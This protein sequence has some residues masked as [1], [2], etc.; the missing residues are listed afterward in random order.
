MGFC[1]GS[2]IDCYSTGY[3]SGQTRV[4]GLV[5]SGVKDKDG[6]LDCAW[7]IETSGLDTSQGGKGLTTARMQDIQTYLNAGWDFEGETENGT[8]DI[9][10]MPDHDSPRLA[11][12]KDR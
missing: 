8:E 2:I 12:E 3:V 5:G 10:T 7:D 6:V 9:W 4:G 11:W 1:L